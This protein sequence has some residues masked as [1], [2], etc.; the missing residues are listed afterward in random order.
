MPD[1]IRPGRFGRSIAVGEAT[2]TFNLKRLCNI[3]LYLMSRTKEHEAL[4]PALAV[5]FFSMLVIMFLFEFTKQALIPAISI[6]ESHAITIVVTSVMAILIIYFPLR[7]SYREQ[8]KAEEALRL[9]QEAE[10]NLRTSEMQ[11]RSFVE[12]VEDSIYTVDRDTR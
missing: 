2:D 7:S 1:T 8:Q 6:W 9:R 11:Y 12:S 10:E 5:V 3:S 4:Y